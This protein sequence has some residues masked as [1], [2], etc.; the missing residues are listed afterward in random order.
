[1]S[2]KFSVVFHRAV[3]HH[4]KMRSIIYENIMCV[5]EILARQSTHVQQIIDSDRL[6]NR[7]A[8]VRGV[9]KE[10]VYATTEKRVTLV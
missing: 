5:R 4:L 2:V 10:A 6:T 9:L 8:G 7:V 1:M 3:A